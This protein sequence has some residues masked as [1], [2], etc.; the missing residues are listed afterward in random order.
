NTTDEADEDP[1]PDQDAADSSDPDNEPGGQLDQLYR[2]RGAFFLELFNPWP[3]AP[4]PSADVHDRT[5]ASEDGGIELA[6]ESVPGSPVWRILVTRETDVTK[7]PDAPAPT[8]RPEI[9]RGVYFT[10]GGTFPALPD[11][12]P[13]FYVGGTVPPVPP[14]RPG[15]Y[16]VVGSGTDDGAGNYIAHLG[17]AIVEPGIGAPPFHRIELNPNN[18]AEPVKLV[19]AEGGA[20]SVARYDLDP[21]ATQ[22]PVSA[23]AEATVSLPPAPATPARLSVAD[24]AIINEPRRLT[25]SEPA[26]GY[27]SV[28]GNVG[29]YPTSSE[30]GEEGEYR[31]GVDPA[32]PKPDDATQP[33]KAIDTPLDDGDD[34]LRQ[35]DTVFNEAGGAPAGR[36]IFL[37][38]L[39]NP[40]LPYDAD[41]NP[42]RTIDETRA[43]VTVF[44]GRLAG[45]EE[46]NGDRNSSPKIRGTFSSIERG[47]KGMNPPSDGDATPDQDFD[48]W[49]QRYPDKEA[50]VKDMRAGVPLRAGLRRTVGD[51]SLK[52][53]PTNTLGFLNRTFM[54][55]TEGD[56]GKIRVQ[57]TEPFP[58]M[59][60]NN[61]PFVS[62]GELELV[63]RLPSHLLLSNFAMYA[64]GG[65]PYDTPTED[66]LPDEMLDP[67]AEEAEDSF[68]HLE[69]LRYQKVG[70]ADRVPRNLYRLLDYV[71]TPSLF[72]GTQKW[73]NPAN[74]KATTPISTADDPRLVFQP[75]FNAVSEFRQPGRINLNTIFSQNVWED[76][77]HGTSATPTT[78]NVTGLTHPG[79]PW[80]DFARSRR[81]LGGNPLTLDATSPTMFA[82]P[83]RSADTGDLVPLPTMVR[84]GVDCTLQRSIDPTTAAPG[85]TPLFEATTTKL[86]NHA[87]RN[88]FFRKQPTTRLPNLVTTRS[89]VYAVWVTIGFFEVEDAGQNQAAFQAA[90]SA[91][92]M[93][94]PQITAMF[95]RVYPDGYML[96][97]E[98][99]IDTGE[100]RRMRGFY[101]IDRTIPAGFEP[102]VDHNAENVIRLR[103]RIE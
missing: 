95:K 102:G 67:K 86:H 11:M 93:S 32:N 40:L 55:K 53:I 14:V 75:P 2:P 22:F 77:F 26:G 52:L 16:L 58:W 82:N 23:P 33:A 71:E 80:A 61:R 31:F 83:F 17:Q 19:D 38:R 21:A 68:A 74:Y 72:V 79:P 66:K 81:G 96:G 25:I 42:Y 12:A 99:G 3:V 56:V 30:P 50:D 78:P 35:L 44:S 7:H 101:I 94:G 46:D 54:N 65:S 9:D 47:Y 87:E 62:S 100:I 10:K 97:N 49:S 57:P 8:D 43:Y 73:L 41:F 88:P 59:T 69:N 45:T 64:A 90:H 84:A 6:K 98:D 103:R 18:V 15:R 5:A 24:V 13:A 39:A 60:W 27:P 20:N 36:R 34:E 48:L 28:V 1:E 70:G 89:N 91:L 85:A 4:A 63:P 92:G 29:F 37:Q 51:Y 76:L